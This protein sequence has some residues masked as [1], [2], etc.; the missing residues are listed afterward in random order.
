MSDEGKSLD[1]ICRAVE[2]NFAGW[3]LPH[4]QAFRNVMKAALDHR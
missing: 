2:S 1:E 4:Q 3:S